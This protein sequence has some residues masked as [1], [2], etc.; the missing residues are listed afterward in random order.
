[1]K[2]TFWICIMVAITTLVFNSC[3]KDDDNG[4]SSSNVPDYLVGTWVMD[5]YYKGDDTHSVWYTYEEDGVTETTVSIKSNGKCNGKGLLING[6]G[7][8]NV[9]TGN[10]WDDGYWA[11]IRFY[12][13][14]QITGTATLT[15]YNNDR[16]TGYVKI[17]GY[18][19]KTFIFKKQ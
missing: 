17:D 1:M 8:I 11:I 6:D 4:N 14:G 13:S 3:S 2:K 10:K 16:L 19:Q 18:P 9:T 15:S 7:E 5:G 12:K